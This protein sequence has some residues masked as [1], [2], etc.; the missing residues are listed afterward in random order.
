MVQSECAVIVV[1]RDHA[2]IKITVIDCKLR[3]ALAFDGQ[4]VKLLTTEAFKRCDHIC[5]DALMGLGMQV[6]EVQIAPINRSIIGLVGQGRRVGHHLNAPSNTQIIH[7][8]HDVRCS[9][10]NRGDARAAE[11]IQRH[12]AAFGAPASVQGRH[13]AH[14]GPLI[15][16]LRTTADNK[17][18]DVVGVQIIAISNGFQHLC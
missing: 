14:T 2:F 7:P 9:K 15:A 8:A 11:T 16:H 5:A 17:I 4:G 18:I 3:A 13:T 6:S 1:D 10:V 12:S